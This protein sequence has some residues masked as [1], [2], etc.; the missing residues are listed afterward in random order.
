MPF[1]PCRCIPKEEKERLG[2]QTLSEVQIL[3]PRKMDLAIDGTEFGFRATTQRLCEL[4][5]Q[6]FHLQNGNVGNY[7][8]YLFVSCTEL[9]YLGVKTAVCCKVLLAEMFC[10]S[11]LTWFIQQI[12]LELHLIYLLFLTKRKESSLS[13]SRPAE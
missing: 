4:K 8:I 5:P 13:F 11:L 9:Q 12:G 3:S 10:V 7:P 2:P 1:H 6:S